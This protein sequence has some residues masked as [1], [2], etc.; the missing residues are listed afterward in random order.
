M[1]TIA[2]AIYLIMVVLC[3]S[4]LVGMVLV[5]GSALFGWIFGMIIVHFS[6]V[7]GLGVAV[8]LKQR[9]DA[10]DRSSIGIVVERGP[11]ASDVPGD[12]YMSWSKTNTHTKN[13]TVKGRVGHDSGVVKGMMSGLGEESMVPITETSD[14]EGVDN[15][16]LER[17]KAKNIAHIL[18][19]SESDRVAKRDRGVVVQSSQAP[20]LISTPSLLSAPSLISESDRVVKR[21]RGVAVQ[22]SQAPSMVETSVKSYHESEVMPRSRAQ[23]IS[24]RYFSTLSSKRSSKRGD[25]AS[26]VFQ[27][28]ADTG[29]WDR[30]RSSQRKPR[31]FMGLSRLASA[32][33]Q[34]ESQTPDF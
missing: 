10:G 32:G 1:M 16:T 5:L 6:L 26:S 18:A 22:S 34:A 24:G 2:L 11:Q 31:G 28:E 17:D 13:L 27:S 3:V 8:F 14:D 7:L 29:D 19:V 12:D 15:Q 33:S 23:V 30:T 21:D 20:S 25:V 4:A 9:R